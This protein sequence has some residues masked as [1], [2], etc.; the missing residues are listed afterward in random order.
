MPALKDPRW[1]KACQLRANG[2]DFIA[3]YAGSGF[4]RKTAN[5]TRFF[6]R[7]D[8]RARVREIQE[9][10]FQKERKVVEIATKKA[11]LEESWIIERAKYVV[12]LALRGNPIRDA[13]GQPTGQFDGKTNLRAATDA[14][15]LCSDFKGMRIQRHEIGQPGDFARMTDDEL[16]D[17]L[18]QT[19]QALGLP[20]DAIAGLLTHRTDTE[21]DNGTENNS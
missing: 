4:G 12:E 5:A 7:D 17:S 14:L 8:I 21:T 20:E 10:G 9:E 13:N 1:E 11:G 18:L 16:D 3:A 6:K 2:D 19:A 15:R